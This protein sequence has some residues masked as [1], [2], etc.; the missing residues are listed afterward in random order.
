M[1]TTTVPPHLSLV[2]SVVVIHR[3]LGREC[4]AGRINKHVSLK[5]FVIS[6]LPHDEGISSGWET[7]PSG[8]GVLI[9]RLYA[10]LLS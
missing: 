2:T 7:N 8:V 5:E 6:A 1:D 9:G 4:Q 10:A 3:N